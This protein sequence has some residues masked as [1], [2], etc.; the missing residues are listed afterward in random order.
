MNQR[1]LSLVA[2]ATL[3][4]AAT[5]H[6]RQ[7]GSTAPARANPAAIIDQRLRSAVER[8]DVPGIV[9]MATDRHGVRYTSRSFRCC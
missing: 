7:R 2:A 3:L 5:P 4:L 1:V 8:G 6:G 9:A